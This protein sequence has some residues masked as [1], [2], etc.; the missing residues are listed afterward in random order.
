MKK[1]IVGITGA[2]GSILAKRVLEFMSSLECELNVIATEN[3][4]KVFLYETGD[5]VGD[6]L[7]SIS[8]N[9]AKVT[10][11]NNSDLFSPVAS[12]SYALDCMMIIPCSMSTAG[13]LANGTGDNL[14]CR[15]ADVCLK[16]KTRLVVVPRE[17]PL[18]SIH[19]KNLLTLSE[20]GAAIVPP[21]P[22]FYAK[23]EGL[24]EAYDCIAGRILK[25]AGI[26]N[27]LYEKWRQF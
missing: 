7:G 23:C 14:L 16:E 25:A 8:K 6:F 10:A 13:K 19:L 21:M 1:Y 2:S 22:V 24:D 26:E 15:A 27:P 9:S 18:N 4:K 5:A 12:G 20:S 11:H 17:T 3:A